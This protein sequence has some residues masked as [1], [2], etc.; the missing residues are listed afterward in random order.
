MLLFYVLLWSFWSL[1]KRKTNKNNRKKRWCYHVFKGLKWIL[2]FGFQD[3]FHPCFLVEAGG[4]G[5]SPC[6]LG[7]K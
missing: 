3:A 6:G 1:F 2:M 4:A 5:A 7:F